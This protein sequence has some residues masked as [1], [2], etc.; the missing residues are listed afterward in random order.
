MLCFAVCICQVLS[1]LWVGFSWLIINRWSWRGLQWRV[2][3]A[4]SGGA[5]F[6]SPQPHSKPGV[7]HMLETPALR[8][9]EACCLPIYMRKHN[10]QVEGETLS[11]RIAGTRRGHLTRSSGYVS[12]HISFHS[13][14]QINKIEKGFNSR[15][16]GVESLPS[17]YKTWSLLALSLSLSLSLSHTHTHTHTCTHTH[18]R[19]HTLM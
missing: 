1:W 16:A 19:T 10:P 17:V 14:R 6:E 12:L 2:L 4:L 18:A 13:Q 3:V 7:G 9:P 11:Q 15:S 8:P 5:E